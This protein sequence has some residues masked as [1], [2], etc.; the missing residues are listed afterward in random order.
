MRQ[1]VLRFAQRV[2]A[3]CDAILENPTQYTPDVVS[4]AKGLLKSAERI[5]AKLLK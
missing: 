4:A 5:I 3:L 2:T 1:Y